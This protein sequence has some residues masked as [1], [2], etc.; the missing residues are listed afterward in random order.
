VFLS[1]FLSFG[2][3][4]WTAGILLGLVF[5]TFF[6]WLI[7]LI[8]KKQYS[9][10]SLY[11]MGMHAVTWPLLI[12]EIRNLVSFSFPSFYSL[13]FLILMVALIFFLKDNKEEPKVAKVVKKSI[14]SKK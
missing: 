9:Y 7:N 8:F 1:F 12:T 6:I 10:G 2:S 5:L 14:R 11:K 13:I 3:L 4:F